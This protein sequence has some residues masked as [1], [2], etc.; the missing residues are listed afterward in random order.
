MTER[1]TTIAIAKALDPV[2]PKTDTKETK[3]S[4]P[5][6]PS[7]N[8]ALLQKSLPQATTSKKRKRTSNTETTN[9]PK[10]KAQKIKPSLSTYNPWRPH[11]STSRS[12]GNPLLVLTSEDKNIRYAPL[13][14]CLTM[15][16]GRYVAIDC[17]MVG[18]GPKGT[19][20]LLARVAIVNYLGQVL[21]DV[22]VKPTLRVTDWRTKYSGIRPADLLNDAGTFIP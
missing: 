4:L 19:E 3:T 5:F 8:W 15:R 16:S 7:Q 14:I 17:E 13:A 6:Q 12:A 18:T 20:D 10:P 1:K 11:A 22:F 21:L 2:L 9:P